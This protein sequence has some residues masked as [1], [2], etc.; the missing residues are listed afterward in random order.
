[1]VELLKPIEQQIMMCDTREETLMLACA[2]IH[3]AQVI[4][5]AHI[6]ERGRKE[7]FTFPKESKR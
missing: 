5:E 2:M 1:M 4:L 3:K 7:I 6:G